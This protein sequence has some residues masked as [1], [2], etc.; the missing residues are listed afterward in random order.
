MNVA[1]SKISIRSVYKIFGARAAEAMGL[2]KSGTSKNEVLASTD[3]IVGINNVNL[4][5]QKAETF[6]I[7][8][9]SGS[10]KSTLIR[11]INR[12]IEPTAG[13]ILVD[14]EDV[15]GLSDKDL[16][17][18]RRHKISMVFQKF[19]LLPHK[20]VLANVAYPLLISGAAIAKANEIAAEQINLVGLTGFEDKYPHELSGGMQQRVGLAR[21][22]ST[23]ADILMMDEAF[24]ALDPMIRNDMQVQ[25]KELQAR[26]HKTIVFITHDLDEALFL[27]DHIAILKDG[28]LRQCDT[29]E[30]ILLKPADDYV[31]RFVR[32]VNSAR[33]VKAGTVGEAFATIKGPSAT[34][35]QSL[36][37]LK[38]MSAAIV[39]TDKYGK[40]VAAASRGE[41][42]SGKAPNAAIT[43]ST[44]SI[45]EEVL[46]LLASEHDCVV[47]VDGEG[48]ARGVITRA[49]MIAALSRKKHEAP[50][51]I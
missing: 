3:A 43:C 49:G 14:G 51:E 41:L 21:A 42:Q 19:A 37:A 26:L 30:N 16:R 10:G 23:D 22:L 17:Q 28:E 40:I 18:L 20:T 32:D 15:I 27:G 4:E 45:L 33:V 2:L 1:T 50:K 46:P 7:M 12:L 35:Q 25:L 29:G 38:E 5:I 11:H 24:S 8:G 13:Q 47:L 44:D 36:K 9:L 48:R 39:V 34:V 31:K 6:V